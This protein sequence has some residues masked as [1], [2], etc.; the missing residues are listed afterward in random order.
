MRKHNSCNEGLW[1]LFVRSNIWIILPP[2]AEIGPYY[3]RPTDVLWRENWVI[4]MAAGNA[5]SWVA[6]VLI[7]CDET[8]VPGPLFIKRQDR[9]ISWN[10]DIWV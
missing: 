3:S 1:Y 4:A 2:E 7:K 9:K 10:R 8:G 5:I 6:V